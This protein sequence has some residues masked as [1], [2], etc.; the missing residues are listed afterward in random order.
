MAIKTLLHEFRMSD[1]EDVAVYAAQPIYEWQQTEAGQWCMKHATNQQWISG[2]DLTG[3]GALV[4]IVGE[5][6]PVDH[7]YFMLK[8]NNTKDAS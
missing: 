5:L 2:F 4:R 1:V 8:Y 3:F 6:E 7:T